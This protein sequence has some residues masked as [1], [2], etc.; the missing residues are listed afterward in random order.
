MAVLLEIEPGPE[1]KSRIIAASPEAETEDAQA[2]EHLEEDP[3][4]GSWMPLAG[5]LILPEDPANVGSAQHPYRSGN[6]ELE[7]GDSKP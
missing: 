7:P 4:S 1:V 6:G 2:S 3:A 5:V